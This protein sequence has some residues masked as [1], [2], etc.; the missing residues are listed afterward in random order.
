MAGLNRSVL[1]VNRKGGQREEVRGPLWQFITCH[2][3]R[4]TFGT[5]LLD[6][7]ADLAAAQD[8][9]GHASIQN[10]R[11]YA[12]SREAQRHVTT[13][14]AFGNLR[15]DAPPPISHTPSPS[16]RKPTT[17]PAPL[18]KATRVKPA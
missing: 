18:R 6:G 13:L 10:T 17:L 8:W 9:L 16:V 3:A 14:T 2:V 7:G 11:R 1:K 4:H 5:L 12:K 15:G